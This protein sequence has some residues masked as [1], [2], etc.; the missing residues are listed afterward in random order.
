MDTSLALE[1]VRKHATLERFR[2][3]LVEIAKQESPETDL[4]EAEP[5]LLAFIRDWVAP[6]LPGLGFTDVKIDAMGNLVARAPGSG[7][8]P[9]LLYMC[10][11][12]NHA[13]ETMPNPYSGAVIDGRPYGI[14]G[15][16]VWGRGLSEQKS[17]LAA[18]LH[19]FELLQ[20]T[21][22][23]LNGTL[24]FGLS[25]AGEC[26]RHDSVVHMVERGGLQADFGIQCG[27]TQNQ[28]GLGNK[29][30][31]DTLITVKGKPSHI[32]MPWLGKNAIEGARKV[33]DV[34]DQIQIPEEE[35]HPVLG[36]PTLVVHAIKSEPYNVLTVPGVCKM[37]LDRRVLPGY[38]LFKIYKELEAQIPQEIDGFEVQR[39]IGYHQF[40]NEVS[41]DSA[42]VRAIAEARKAVTGQAPEYFF[43]HGA[44][45]A[46]YFNTVVGMPMVMFGSGEPRFA[47]TDQEM[48]SVE[49]AYTT[50]QIYATTALSMLA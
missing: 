44:L 45:D 9:S 3:R 36:R 41:R 26:G 43:K 28:V 50:M 17:S 8:G 12:M 27:A 47:H 35:I 23:K 32:S 39:E 25:T 21:G 18:V 49:Q 34:I 5:Q 14:E 19:A 31:F 42:I 11:A 1:I 15:E 6:K 30:R 48:V 13:P 4:L 22:V 40:P 38:D 2:A 37:T 46:G 29:G 16:C 33:M 7:A 24:V 20:E 10:H